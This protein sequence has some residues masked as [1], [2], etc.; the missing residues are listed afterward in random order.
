MWTLRDTIAGQRA[1]FDAVEDIVAQSEDALRGSGAVPARMLDNHDT[2][3]F[4]S[5]SAGNGGNDP[6]AAP[7]PQPESAAVYAKQRMALALTFSLPGM[8]VLYYGDEVALAGASDP[9]SRRVM[10]APDA[11]S[12]AQQK[13][14]AFVQRLGTLRGCLPALR[15][16][17]RIPVWADGTTYAFAR[18]AGDGAPALALFST[19]G[20]TTMISVPGGIVPPGDYVD[21]LSGEPV[22]LSGGDLVSIDPLTAKIL[23]PA[24]SPCRPTTP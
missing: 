20:A 12:P 14:L 17:A 21:A 10:P 3:R 8:P 9:D 13:T 4:A 11:L 7:P 15:R 2:S 1:G 19:A 22:T 18:D 16:G 5:E 23:V 24:K 6:W